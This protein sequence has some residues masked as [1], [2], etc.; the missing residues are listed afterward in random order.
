MRSLRFVLLAA[1]VLAGMNLWAQSWQLVWADEF[2]NGI[3]PDWVFETG[4]GSGGWGNNELQYYRSQ[5]ASVSNGQLVITAR[6][7]NFGGMQYTSA[8][9]KTQGRK[10]WRYGRVEARISMPSFQ[11]VWPA[12]WMLGDNI[13]SVGWPACGEIDVMEHVNTGGTVHGTIHWQDNNGNYA[14][15]GGNTSTSITSFHTY[16]IEWDANAIR[17]Y[18]DGA[19]YHVANIAGG[20]NGTSEF[21]NNFFIILNMAIGGNWPG[22]T[23]DNNAFP[24]TML[25]DYVR[26]YTQGTPPPSGPPIG[27]TIALRG[28]NNQY[29]SGEN[30]TLPMRC[31]RATAQ[32]W[33]HFTVVDA[34]GGQIAL[35]SM[36]KY[37]SS[38]NGT[39]AMTA[40]ATTIGAQ[41]RFTW[42]TNSD[43]TISLRGSN[44]MYVSSENGVANMMCNRATIQGWE[45]FTR[46]TVSGRLDIGEIVEATGEDFGSDQL[47]SERMSL[48]PNPASE[49]VTI[50][51]PRPSKVKMV[52]MTGVPIFSQDVEESVTLSNLAAGVY[53]VNV[54]NAD[55]T[56]VK[57]LLV[58]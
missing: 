11:G 52:S 46:V 34:G 51:V 4:T 24:A 26:V 6:R 53:L 40:N 58:R 33:E 42:V 45:K 16:A 41:Q 15:Y 44:N 31:N 17:W 14:N 19:Q 9:M 39:A 21:H 36:N 50:Q 54:S 20:I 48:Y 37:V 18:V 22:F 1:F 3:G 12:F 35:R 30:G 56:A 28:N 25:V 2:T 38:G 47:I 7:E 55:G 32:A 13:T 23:I 5:N 27:Q 29:V 43:G 10:S 8:R 49:S 57:R